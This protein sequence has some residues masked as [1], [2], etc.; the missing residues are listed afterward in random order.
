MA[1]KAK[2][3]RSKKCN[4]NMCIHN[5]KSNVYTWKGWYIKQGFTNV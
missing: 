2:L 1:K 5:E 4:I 3:N